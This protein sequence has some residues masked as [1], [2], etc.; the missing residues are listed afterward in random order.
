VIDD[1]RWLPPG[2]PLSMRHSGRANVVFAD[3]HVETVRREF[4]DSSH[5][6]HY[7]PEK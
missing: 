1:G 2:Y 7:D 3:S 6:E 5:P 4:A